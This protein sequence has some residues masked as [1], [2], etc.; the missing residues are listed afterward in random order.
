MDTL[1][2][3]MSEMKIGGTKE[4]REFMKRIVTYNRKPQSY[5]FQLPV[6]FIYHFTLQVIL[7]V[8]MFLLTQDI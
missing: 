5:L 6:T 4:T 2:R 7:A 1:P 3:E 8:S